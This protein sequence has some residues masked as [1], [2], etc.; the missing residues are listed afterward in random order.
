M[1]CVF[2]VFD[3]LRWTHFMLNMITLDTSS[4][5]RWTHFMLNM[6]TLDTSS[7]L[8][9]THFMLGWTRLLYFGGHTSCYVGHVFCGREVE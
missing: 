3:L 6:I 8:R 2:I 7:V 9:W 5:L 4:V 1:T